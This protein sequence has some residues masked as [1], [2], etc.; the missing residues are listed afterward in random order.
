MN[1][2]FVIYIGVKQHIKA[3]AITSEPVVG[4]AY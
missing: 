1:T 2:T 3:R 4:F